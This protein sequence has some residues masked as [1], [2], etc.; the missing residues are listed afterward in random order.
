MTNKEAIALYE[1]LGFRRIPPH[2]PAQ[3]PDQRPPSSR[4]ATDEG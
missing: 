2:H 1:K 4:T 3:E